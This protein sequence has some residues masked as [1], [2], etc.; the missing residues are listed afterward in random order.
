MIKILTQPES[1]TVRLKRAEETIT[2]HCQAETLRDEQLEYKWY[3]LRG[4]E[5]P[6]TLKK[7]GK[8]VRSAK[9]HID[10]PLK[11]SSKQEWRYFCEVS[12]ADHFVASEVAV[13][14]LQSGEL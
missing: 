8:K 9:P 2:L 11:L 4:N 14:R 10:I 12:V 1:Q 13:I 7:G 3:Y 5:N 6:A